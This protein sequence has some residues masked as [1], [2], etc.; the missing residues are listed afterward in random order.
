M[1]A[2]TPPESPLPRLTGT[3][4]DALVRGYSDAQLA[5]CYREAAR[6]PGTEWLRLL[7]EEIGRRDAHGPQ[8]NAGE[9]CPQRG[10]A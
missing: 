2:T 1:S 8:G 10:P 9:D 6:R 5:V 7:S 4:I 3:G